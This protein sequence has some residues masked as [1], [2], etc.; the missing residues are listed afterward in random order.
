MLVK[1]TVSTL[2]LTT[3]NLASGILMPEQ[4]NKIKIREKG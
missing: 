3:Q 1:S 4:T 2:D